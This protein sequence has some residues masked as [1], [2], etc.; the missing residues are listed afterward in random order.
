MKRSFNKEIYDQVDMSAKLVLKKLI[1]TNSEYTLESDLDEELYKAG[2]IVFQK[3]NKKIIFENEVRY[4]FD[5]IVESFLTIHIPIR[6]QNTPAHYYVVWK[7][8]FCQFILIKLKD[9]RKYFDNIVE[10]KC[11]QEMGSNVSYVEEFIDIPK[12]ETSWYVV[13][14]GY[15]PIKLDY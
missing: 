8:D 11:T 14:Q 3:G 7:P 13:G 15:K 2:D 10:V 1:E 5:R 6:K 4:D 12:S 9:I